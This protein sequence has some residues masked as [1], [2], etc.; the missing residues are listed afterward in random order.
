MLARFRSRLTYSNVLATVAIFVALG[1]SSYAVSQINGKNIKNRSIA[2]KKLKKR[3]VTGTEIKRGVI[4]P[5]KFGRLPA[6]RAFHSASQS[7]AASNDT[8]L[9]FNS[10]RFDTA[11]LHGTT[12]D[13]SRLTAP[14]SGIY[15]ITA[16]VAWASND[17]GLRE[18]SLKK[19]GATVI[20]RSQVPAVT[21]AGTRQELST[22]YRLLAG[23]F[24]EVEVYQESG[25]ALNVSSDPQWTPEFTMAWVA[26]K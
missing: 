19:N 22:L 3:T 6:A 8:I 17:S 14:I 4:T 15:Y 12:T 25:G 16:H 1:G 23:D 18:V 11:A 13:N 10:E 5:S 20:A 24:V 7:I 2:G 26:P 21:S 9:A